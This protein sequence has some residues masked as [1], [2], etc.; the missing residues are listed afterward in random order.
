MKKFFL[1][2][3]MLAGFACPLFSGESRIAV[4]NLEKVFREYYKSKIAEDMIRRQ[5]GV[6]QSYLERLLR[7]LKAAQAKAANAHSDAQNIGLSAAE[8]KKADKAVTDAIRIVSEKRAEI[9]LYRSGRARDIKKLED[10]KRTEIMND[11]MAE[12][13][14]RTAAGGY[15]YVFDS[16]GKTTNN[17]SALLIFPESHDLTK[18][19]ISNLNRRASNK[20]Q[21]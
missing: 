8:R 5:T 15:T 19:V 21:Q 18:E 11:I 17:Q 14:K 10:E 4:V 3:I 2:L 1:L 9:E 13:K 6:Y 7:E 12:L 20:K 16:S